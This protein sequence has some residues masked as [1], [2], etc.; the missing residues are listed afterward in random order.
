[1]VADPVV[2]GFDGNQGTWRPRV[3]FSHILLWRACCSGS[4]SVPGTL[5]PGVIPRIP[6]TTPF[7]VS[8]FVI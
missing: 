6:L 1:M 7:I 4:D 2:A 5:T 8:G 3:V